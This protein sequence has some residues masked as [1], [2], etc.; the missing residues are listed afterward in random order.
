MTGLPH[1][2]PW[3]LENLCND[4][5]CRGRSRQGDPDGELSLLGR[6][7]G[8]C[9]VPGVWA[10]KSAGLAGRLFQDRALVK[11]HLVSHRKHASVPR[12]LQSGQ[13][14]CEGAFWD[15]GEQGI[16]GPHCAP[17]H[18]KCTERSELKAECQPLIWTLFP[19]GRQIVQV[20]HISA[21]DEIPIRSGSAVR[22]QSFLAQY[23]IRLQRCH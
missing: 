2:L 13:A 14:C 5:Q 16:K 9:Q 15:I 18:L 11:G 19:L 12:L 1:V 3:V 7:G 22:L 6:A 10:V 8:R 20:T 4:R 17:Q 23:I 21:L